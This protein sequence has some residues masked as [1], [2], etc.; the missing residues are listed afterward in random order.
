[1]NSGLLQLVLHGVSLNVSKQVAVKKSDPY[2][3]RLIMLFGVINV[4][5]RAYKLLAVTFSS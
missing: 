2:C 3:S 1:M 5:S 4:Y